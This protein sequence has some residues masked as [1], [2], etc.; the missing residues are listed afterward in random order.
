MAAPSVATTTLRVAVVIPSYAGHLHYLVSQLESWASFATD[1]RSLR[2][3]IVLSDDERE[4]RTFQSA[5]A[6]LAR[7]VPHLHLTSLREAIAI[8]GGGE[9]IKDEERFNKLLGRPRDP[10]ERPAWP[11]ALPYRKLNNY[12]H[13]LQSAKKLYGCLAASTNAA[14]DWCFVTDSE[15]LLIRC[16]ALTSLVAE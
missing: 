7:L 10:D 13:V 2:F 14:A 11:G 12:K 9:S 1:V 5:L 8:A 15:T 4:R 3:T 16:V 6:G